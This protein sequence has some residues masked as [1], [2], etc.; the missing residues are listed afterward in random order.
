MLPGQNAETQ[1]N[2]DPS[3]NPSET[4]KNYDA[5]TEASEWDSPERAQKLVEAFIGPGSLVLDIGTGTGQAVKGYRAKGAA[6]VGIDRDPA[7]LEE[8]CIN[9]ELADEVRLGDIN[10]SLPIVDLAGEV[11]VAQAIGVLEFAADIGSVFD[12]V[13]TTLRT[14]GVFVF[15]VEALPAGP[16]TEKVESYPDAGVTVHRHTADEI[17]TLLHENGFGLLHEESY[18]AYVRGDIEDGKVPYH[19]FLARKV[20]S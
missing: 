16:G 13:S 19:L 15:T 6:V 12:Q 17:E 14:G 3:F 18:G 10:E 2:S 8:A 7:M 1:T 4:A 20:T 5:D 9:K 11:D